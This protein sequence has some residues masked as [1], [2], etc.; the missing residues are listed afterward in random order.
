MNRS[1]VVTLALGFMATITAMSGGLSIRIASASGNYPEIPGAAF[2]AEDQIHL[3]LT[4]I[5]IGSLCLSFFCVAWVWRI[6]RHKEPAQFNALS[7]LITAAEFSKDSGIIYLDANRR[8]LAVS[9]LPAQL[10]TLAARKLVGKTVEQVYS[11]KFARLLYELQESAFATRRAASAEI[12]DW[13]L[14]T[15]VRVGG[16]RV[17][18][19]PSFVGDVL[20]GFVIIFRPTSEIRLTED[21]A[22]LH[23]QHYRALFDALTIGVAVF[24]PAIC[25]ADGGADAYLA[26]A[27]E[28][29]K[30]MFCGVSLPYAEPCSV[31]WPS[32]FNQ[33]QLRAGLRAIT[34]GEPT[35]RCEFF[36]PVLGKHMDVGLSAFPGGK[37][38]ATFSDQTEHRLNETQVLH[39]NDQLQ[40]TLSKQRAQLMAVLADISFFNDAAVAR[41]QTTLE[42]LEPAVSVASNEKTQEEVQHLMS[43]MV[44]Y[45]EVVNLPYR[46]SYLV[47][48]AEVTNRLQLALSQQFPDIQWV[49]G[50]L[51]SL[52]A[53]PTVIEAILHRLLECI[54]RLP[55]GRA[56]KIEVGEQR[57][58]LNTG[59]YLRGSGFDTTSLFVELPSTPASL[60]W[61]LTSDL[62]VAAARR[63]IAAHGGT[64]LLCG[65]ENGADF[66]ISFTIGAP[67]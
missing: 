65:T 22:I 29:F 43:Q 4:V 33:P 64:L 41:L 32:F 51:P 61:T 62:D 6:Q 7:R 37:I 45:H 18:T 52:V 53:S 20:E 66:Q 36:S 17:I 3:L 44:Y 46:E 13:S 14:Y 50:K 39:L 9:Q 5:G 56:A 59:L 48:T 40:Q 60:D 26:E 19:T 27:N 58:F 25:A 35:A 1:S 12:N 31:V 15:P 10:A 11:S 8:I 54:C 42:K 28:A 30:N 38:L 24:R 34:N 21:A 55:A 67:L 63:M 16:V 57:D 2:N 47:S 23:Q 49:I